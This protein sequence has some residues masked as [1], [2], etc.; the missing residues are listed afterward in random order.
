M[1]RRFSRTAAG[2][3]GGLLL[4]LVAASPASAECQPRPAEGDRVERPFVFTATVR[5]LETEPDV[6]APAEEESVLWHL[7]LDIDRIYAGAVR[8]PLLLTGST[9]KGG[10]GRGC[11][12]FLGDRVSEGDVLFVALDEQIPFEANRGLFGNLLVWRQ[13]ASG[14][15]F[16]EAALQDGQDPSAYPKAARQASSLAEILAAVDRLA[17]PETATQPTIQQ[18]DASRVTYLALFVWI[19]GVA[20]RAVGT[21][22]SGTR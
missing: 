19:L 6:R 3:A 5:G 2:L 20:A 8:D 22:R 15:Q 9:S 12:Y 14:W 4:A 16:Y 13:T 7:A 17:M 1:Y 10:I 18:A 11:G 21:R